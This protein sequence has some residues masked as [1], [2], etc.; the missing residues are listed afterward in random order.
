MRGIPHSFL[1]EKI[2][3]FCAARTDLT[4]QGL[5]ACSCAAKPQNLMFQARLMLT[6]FE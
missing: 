1:A 5:F 2:L 3:L 4:I 6:S